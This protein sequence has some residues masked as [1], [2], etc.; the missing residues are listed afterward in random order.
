MSQTVLVT[1]A[2]GFIGRPLSDALDRAGCAVI[3]HS[4]A[5]GDIA[6]CVLPESATGAARTPTESGAV[7]APHSVLRALPES[8][9]GAARTPTESGTV[10]A[11]HSVLRALPEGGV[12][13]V[14]HLAARTFVPD[15]WSDPVSFYAT[16]V[17]GTVN[18][19]EFCRRH[20]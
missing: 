9:K 8:A 4:A 5:D 18:V 15:S 19:A 7:F 12:R 13:H 10:F 11:P 3:R 1:G 20:E 2:T 17:L 6:C 14:Y 16:N